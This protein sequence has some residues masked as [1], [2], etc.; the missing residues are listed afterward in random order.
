MI[1]NLTSNRFVLRKDKKP[2]DHSK[3]PPYN[4]VVI[5]GGIIEL[6]FLVSQ[7]ADHDW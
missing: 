1:H 6:I 7:S 5:A 2:D 3:F 4:D